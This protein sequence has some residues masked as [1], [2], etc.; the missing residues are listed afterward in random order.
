MTKTHTLTP[1]QSHVP[2]LLEGVGLWVEPM[3]IKKSAQDIRYDPDTNEITY[4][5]ALCGQ[6]D[7]TI[8]GSEIQ[9]D[10]ILAFRE[11]FRAFHQYPCI[12]EDDEEVEAYEVEYSN[13]DRTHPIYSRDFEN[14]G[15]AWQPASEMPDEFIRL[16]Y[17]VL[18]VEVG[19]LGEIHYKE[20]W[21]LG[22]DYG[23]YEGGY[24]VLDGFDEFKAIEDFWNPQ[25]PDHPYDPRRFVF[26]YKV[27]RIEG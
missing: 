5:D 13:G 8:D 25:F 3:Y 7:W 19:R 17:K 4:F 18:G 10:D 20:W 16:K 2:A 11:E 14:D 15:Y 21:D 1:H 22:L 9:P 23:Q 26:K 12:T 24:E 27:E 6:Q